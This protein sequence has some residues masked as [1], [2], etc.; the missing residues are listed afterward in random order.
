MLHL[1]S[2]CRETENGIWFC[3]KIFGYSTDLLCLL[4]G[5]M[6][7]HPQT[8]L[9]FIL[10]GHLHLPDDLKKNSFRQL[11]FSNCDILSTEFLLCW[12]TLLGN[13]K[14]V[15]NDISKRNSELLIETII[16]LRMESKV[17]G[18]LVV[19]YELVWTLVKY[20]DALYFKYFFS[21]DLTAH[22]YVRL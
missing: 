2:L 1:C 6:N 22:T 3:I 9:S 14:N 7:I 21:F 4:G 12:P 8:V 5:R 16:S 15:S 19:K 13:S 20:Y 18:N 17:K 11:N 10:S